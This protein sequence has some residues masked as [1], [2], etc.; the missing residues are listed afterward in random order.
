MAE[1]GILGMD[2]R[3]MFSSE[4][5]NSMAPVLDPPPPPPSPSPSMT[6]PTPK[7]LDVPPGITFAIAVPGVIMIPGIV[8]VIGGTAVVLVIG[9]DIEGLG[10]E[11]GNSNKRDTGLL[12]SSSEFL[13]RRSAL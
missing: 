11:P 8:G 1:L 10:D 13:C 12:P 6:I 7:P 2:D 5:D 4:S 3:R 9:G